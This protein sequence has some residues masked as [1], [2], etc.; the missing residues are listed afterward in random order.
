MK[1]LGGIFLTTLFMAAMIL[2]GAAAGLTIYAAMNGEAPWQRADSAAADGTGPADSAD[3]ADSGDSQGEEPGEAEK[4]GSASIQEG[5][6]GSSYVAIKSAAAAADYEGKPAVVV[7]YS[8]TNNS[9][10]TTSAYAAIQVKASQNGIKL[11]SAVVIDPG[12]FDSSS[13]MQQLRPGRAINVQSA[14]HLKSKTDPIAV[15]ISEL[16]SSSGD[17]VVMEFDPA[18]LG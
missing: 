3:N 8:W 13:Y 9:D 14:F 4:P 17:T 11:D 16:G 7:T 12:K 18:E 15:E 1:K 2:L 5:S 6:L 10:S